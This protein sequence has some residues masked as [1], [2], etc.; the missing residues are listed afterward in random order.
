MTPAPAA[1][2]EPGAEFRRVLVGWDGSADAIAALRAAVAVVGQHAGHVVALAVLPLAPHFDAGRDRTGELDAAR[3]QVSLRF[4]LASHNLTVPGGTRVS[5]QFAEGQHVA[6]SL[7]DHS[8]EHGFDLLVVGRQ[9]EGGVLPHRLGR[10]TEAVI[11]SSTV[12]LL[13]VSAK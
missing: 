9:G 8:A 4:E 6:R 10:V 1:S 12:P 3:H 13:L 7:C 2:T 11:R 5:L